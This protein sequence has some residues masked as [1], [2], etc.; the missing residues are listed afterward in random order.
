MIYDLPKLQA[1]FRRGPVTALGVVVALVMLT[2]FQIFETCRQLQESTDDL[3]RSQSTL[4]AIGDT[5]KGIVNV[6]TG[7]RG[8][9]I[10]GH[11]SFLEPYVTYP[12]PADVAAAIGPVV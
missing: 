7:E 1:N 4:I 5:V 2:E 10:S 3:R 11:E 6:E 9:L 12:E 8:F